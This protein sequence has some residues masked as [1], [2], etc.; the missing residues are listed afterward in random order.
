MADKPFHFGKHWIV[1]I[2]H[3][4]H[5]A[6]ADGFHPARIGAKKALDGKW[7]VPDAARKGKFLRVE[8]E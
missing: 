7:Y 6:R 3:N 5:E 4:P 8:H 1:P 2:D